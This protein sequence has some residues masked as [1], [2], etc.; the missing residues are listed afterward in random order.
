MI[1]G[2]VQLN[3]ISFVDTDAYYGSFVDRSMKIGSLGSA[4]ELYHIYYIILYWLVS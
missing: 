4:V 3:A 1:N 2:K